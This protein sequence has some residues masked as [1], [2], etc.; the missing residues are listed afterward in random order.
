MSRSSFRNKLS[1]EEKQVLANGPILTLLLRSCRWLGRL[2]RD[3]SAV[4]AI[5]FAILAPA[6]ITMYIGAVEL[7]NA[8]TID[9]RTSAVTA[10]AADLVAQVKTV[11]TADVKDVQAAATDVMAPYPTSPL[12][13]VLSSVVADA[14]NIGKVVWSCASNGASP[15][16]PNST[17]PTPTGLTQA[18]SSVIVAEVT[19][20]FTP[21]TNLTVFGA[22]TAFTMKRTFYARPRKSVKVDKTDG[23]AC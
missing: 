21:L 19:Y 18:D 22:P 9:R 16:A 2:L 5:E 4:S 13:I 1:E 7:G 15:R 14:N 3:Q 8:L 12:K 10:T 20:A 11:T 23:T 6:M 17:Y